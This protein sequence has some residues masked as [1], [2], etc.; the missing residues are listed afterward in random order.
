[1]I[2]KMSAFLTFFS[3][4]H[5]VLQKGYSI[6]EKSKDSVGRGK[7][8]GGLLTDFI[9]SFDCLDH[10]LLTAKLYANGFSFLVFK[11]INGYLSN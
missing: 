5:S 7:V 1:M 4:Q 8:F 9:K 10:E 3:N 6:Q 2:A 11:L